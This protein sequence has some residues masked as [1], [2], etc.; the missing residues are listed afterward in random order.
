M[1][2]CYKYVD[3]AADDD[4]LSFHPSVSYQQCADTFFIVS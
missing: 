2:L 3:A 1:R 4:N